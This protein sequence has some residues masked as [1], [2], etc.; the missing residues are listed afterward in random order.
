MWILRVTVFWPFLAHLLEQNKYGTILKAKNVHINVQ[1]SIICSYAIS[2]R[3]ISCSLESNIS[4]I[5]G[6]FF[7]HLFLP[8]S[9]SYSIIYYLF[10][11]L[12]L[13]V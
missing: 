4:L 10:W 8:Q 11:L 12:I 2:S 9:F 13:N 5:C 6:N 3:N 7:M 1:S